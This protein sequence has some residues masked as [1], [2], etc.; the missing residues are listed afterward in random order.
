MSKKLSN[1]QKKKLVLSDRKTGT[2]KDFYIYTDE[3]NQRKLD[4][5]EFLKKFGKEHEDVMV[6]FNEL[7]QSGNIERAL[8]LLYPQGMISI[9]HYDVKQNIAGFMLY[10]DTGYLNNIENVQN[11]LRHTKGLHIIDS[12]GREID[13]KGLYN[14]LRIFD[15]MK[16]KSDIGVKDNDLFGNIEFAKSDGD[17]Q[18]I[19]KTYDFVNKVDSVSLEEDL[20]TKDYLLSDKKSLKAGKEF[21]ESVKSEF[22]EFD[23][24]LFN[25]I[26][27]RIYL[28]H[29]LF[30]NYR[31]MFIKMV[32]NIAFRP[33]IY[34]NNV[35]DTF[36]MFDMVLNNDNIVIEKWDNDTLLEMDK[37]QVL[38]KFLE[39]ATV[40]KFGFEK[41]SEVSDDDSRLTNHLAL[42]KHSTYIADA[43]DVK[44]NR[45]IFMMEKE[46]EQGL[47]E[48]AQIEFDKAADKYEFDVVSFEQPVTDNQGRIMTEEK[49][50]EFH[51]D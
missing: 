38:D 17:M 47:S 8:R 5:I 36:P 15:D 25:D 27:F 13:L 23:L 10:K 26:S 35:N 45:S 50:S 4:F 20:I 7:Q 49:D 3:T 51:I 40:N 37:K 32:D 46:V 16:D 42:D 9:A 24:G 18:R 31:L 19:N 12:Y 22:P 11:Y 44:Q 33:V 30:V 48:K 14:E 34:E 21:I 1:K 6:D 41:R 43:Q 29:M 28:F 39:N 2:F